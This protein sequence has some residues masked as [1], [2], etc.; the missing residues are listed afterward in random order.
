MRIWRLHPRYLDA[1]GL[2][3][4][5]CEGRLARAVLRGLLRRLR[6]RSPLLML[7]RMLPFGVCGYA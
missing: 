7:D 4:L 6:Q 3:A 5:W 1:V 2:V